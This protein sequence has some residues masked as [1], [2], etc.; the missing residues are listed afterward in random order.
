MDME[1]IQAIDCEDA[2]VKINA[3]NRFQKLA[4]FLLTICYTCTG[5]FII[6]AFIFLEKDPTFICTKGTDIVTCSR[7]EACSGKYTYTINYIDQEYYSW[8][9]DYKMDCNYSFEIGLLGSLLFIGS[10]ISSIISP[11]ASDYIGRAAIIKYSMYARTCVILLPMIF[12]N[13]HV[14]LASIFSL[15][16][17]NSMHSTIPYILLSEYVTTKERDDY[18]TFMF[19][20]E[21]FSGILS[22][23]FFYFYQNWLVFFILNF[24]YGCVFVCLSFYLYESPR[25]LYLNKRYNEAREVLSKIAR[26]NLGKE[27]TFKFNKEQSVNEVNESKITFRT[28]WSNINYRKFIVVHPLVWFLDAFLFFGINFMIKYLNQDVYLLNIIIFFGEAVSYKISSLI[29]KFLSKRST[30]ILSFLISGVSLFAFY[31]IN[32]NLVLL[33]ILIFFA[34]FGAAV[35]LNISSMYTNE[36][37]PTALRGRATAIC[38]FVGKFGG[39]IAPMLVEI[40]TAITLIAGISCI[41]A[42]CIILILP[43][44][45]GSVEFYDE[46]EEVQTKVPNSVIEMATTGDNGTT[47]NTDTIN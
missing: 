18:L 29:L 47:N 27:I 23:I 42:I 34:K 33:M 26:M 37:F 6:N 32:D 13:I 30:M 4:M 20:C 11:I 35:I 31:F 22:T 24:L 7:R 5:A 39:I 15:G 21:S 43:T 38:S 12:H 46:Q 36:S 19:I 3:N 10:M 2:L 17:L 1:T 45:A 28:I 9:N 8:V 14:L 44:K 25:F 40:S 41:F 16:L